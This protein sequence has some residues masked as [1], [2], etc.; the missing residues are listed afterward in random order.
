MQNNEIR[1]MLPGSKIF[2]NRT[3]E[4]LEYVSFP[5]D[6]QYVICKDEDKK[7]VWLSP[8]RIERSN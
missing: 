3:G 6:S 1:E 8:D 4:I 2:D 7:Y 5:S